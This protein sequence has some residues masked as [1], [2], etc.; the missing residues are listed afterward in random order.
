MPLPSVPPPFV[1]EKKVTNYLLSDTHPQGR[2]KSHFFRAFGFTPEQWQQFADAL[3][4]Q[5]TQ[6]ESVG[7][8]ALPD[9]V[10]YVIE[11]EL[12]SPDG[13]TPRIRTVWETRSTDPCPRLITAY[14]A[15]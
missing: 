5:G 11:G 12:I 1:E 7:T 2:S 10:Q 13:R 8:V 4:V 15:R 14:P 3:C 6:G 9:S